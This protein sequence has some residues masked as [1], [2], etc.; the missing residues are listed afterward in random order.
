MDPA[1]GLVAVL[2]VAGVMLP[3]ALWIGSVILRAA[4]GL[5][6][7]VVGGSTP[8]LTYY[9][10]PEGYRRYRQDPSELA[11]PMP[12]TGK[13]MGILLVVGLVDFV[14]RV[15]I[16]MAAALNGGDG[17]MAALI[18]LPVSV[19]VQVT[20]LSSLLPTTLGRAV[21]VLVFQFVIVML[22]AAAIGAVVVAFAVGMAGS[23]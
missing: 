18:A 7:K 1:A 5:T 22:I 17:S 8:D 6:N 4:I 2:C 9:D 21:V 23:R 16:G 12:S 20:M 19:V 14:V 15:A 11:I 13:A 3:V 10:E